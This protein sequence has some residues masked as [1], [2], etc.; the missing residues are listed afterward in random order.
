MQLLEDSRPTFDKFSPR[1]LIR[2]IPGTFIRILRNVFL[3]R[4]C[5]TF[6]IVVVK[7]QENAGGEHFLNNC[8]PAWCLN[9]GFPKRSR[10]EK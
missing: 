10:T 4:I 6:V 9:M 3:A 5:L 1:G 2:K 7:S 8:G